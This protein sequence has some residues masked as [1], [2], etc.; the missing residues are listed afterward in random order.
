[1]PT[2]GQTAFG[3]KKKIRIWPG[4][5]RDRIWP[6][7][8][9][10]E[11]VFQS[12]DRIRPIFVFLVFWSR[13]CVVRGV[14][15][16]CVLCVLCLQDFWWVSSRFLVGVFKIFPPPDRPSAGPPIRRTAHPPLRFPT[17]RG[18]T[19]TP[20]RASLNVLSPPSLLPELKSQFQIVT[21]IIIIIITII[22]FFFDGLSDRP[23]TP[24]LSQNSAFEKLAK[25][26]S[27]FWYFFLA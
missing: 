16:L 25:V 7:R 17:L 9:W 1:M 26:T 15:V 8:I 2:F 5:F 24:L 11:L 21:L 23:L 6:N 10:P 4:H 12:V 14:C 27:V 20:F 22:G 13:L 18:P 19:L 3:P